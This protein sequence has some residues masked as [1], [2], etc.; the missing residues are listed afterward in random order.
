MIT[1]EC[2]NCRHNSDCDNTFQ[3][4]VYGN[5]GL[6]F[7]EPTYEVFEELEKR[8]E[9]LRDMYENIAYD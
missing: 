6:N 4:T 2:S 7:W 1:R 8:Y 5:E 3:C 9:E